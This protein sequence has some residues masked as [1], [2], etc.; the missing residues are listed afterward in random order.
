MKKSFKG[1]GKQILGALLMVVAIGG[2][3]FWEL[4]GREAIL[5]EEVLVA[6]EDIAK[7][8]KILEKDLVAWKVLKGNKVSGGISPEQLDQI[9]GKE[10]KLSLIKNQQISAKFFEKE[11]MELRENQSYFVIKEPWIEMRSSVLR[12]GDTVEI[13]GRTPQDIWGEITERTPLEQERQEALEP[14]GHNLISLGQYK[15]AF[16]KDSAEREVHTTDEMGVVK[17]QH[18][19]RLDS[20]SVIQHIEVICTLEEYLKIKQVGESWD[21]PSLTIVQRGENI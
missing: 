20:T 11:E 7:G 16:V 9:K 14:E 19:E 21:M 17:T 10:L 1:Y 3:L 6:K 12:R 2:L 15:I 18:G 4:S 5:M 8:S 13:F